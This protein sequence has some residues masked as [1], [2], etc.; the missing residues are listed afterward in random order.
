MNHRQLARLKLAQAVEVAR[1]IDGALPAVSDPNVYAMVSVAN[2]RLL[3]R[4]ALDTAETLTILI[5][6][7]DAGGQ[8]NAE[9]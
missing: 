1:R 4:H 2:L 9:A 3:A 5:D 7:L 6:A 8:D